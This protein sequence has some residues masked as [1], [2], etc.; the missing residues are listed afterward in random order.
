MAAV[1]PKGIASFT[2][3]RNLLDD[4]DAADINRLQD[5][6]VAIE[7]TLGSALNSIQEQLSDFQE[8]LAGLAED[9]GENAAADA[10]NEALDAQQ[11][12]DLTTLKS[13]FKTL[14]EQLAAMREGKHTLAAGLTV[15][16]ISLKPVSTGHL[17][18]RPTLIKMN[19]PTTDPYKLYNGVGLTLR[20]GGFWILF[21]H[22]KI[23]LGTKNRNLNN[24]FYQLA[25]DYDGNWRPGMDQ[26]LDDTPNNN[27]G[28]AF[29]MLNAQRAGWFRTGAKIQLRVQHN[30]K[31]NQ[32][33]SNAWLYAVRVRGY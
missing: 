26:R 21:A 6:V 24:G 17:D 25:I 13:N 3:K 1:F 33:L 31:R 27:D 22:C 18:Q 9:L 2:T 7:T 20:K 14:G 5:E 12:R 11:G 16:N 28:Q 29:V 15:A 10:A 19:K 32:L 23:N 30:S 8:D 4:V